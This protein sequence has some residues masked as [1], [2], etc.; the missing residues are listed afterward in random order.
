MLLAHLLAQSRRRIDVDC[1]MFLI[2]GSVVQPLTTVVSIYSTSTHKL[3]GQDGLIPGYCSRWTRPWSSSVT[4]VFDVIVDAWQLRKDSDSCSCLHS[5]PSE[6]P[7]MSMLIMIQKR[8]VRCLL[9]EPTC[10]SRREGSYSSDWI[11]WMMRS[12]LHRQFFHC[13]YEQMIKSYPINYHYC[14]SYLLN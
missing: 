1:I 3:L 4:V 11:G 12:V 14:I 9:A 2:Q 13:Y 8:A 10:R 7:L 5:T 6:L